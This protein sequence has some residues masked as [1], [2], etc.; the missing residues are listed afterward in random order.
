MSTSK[1]TKTEGKGTAKNSNV[2]PQSMSAQKGSTTILTQDPNVTGNRIL[3]PADGPY[4]LT[5][6][7]RVIICGPLSLPGQSL[8]VECGEIGTQSDTKGNAAVISVTGQNGAP[9]PAPTKPAA[10]GSDGKQAFTGNEPSSFPG[11]RGSGGAAGR[12]GTAGGSGGTISVIALSVA[13]GTNLTLNAEGG[14]GGQGQRGERGGNGGKGGTCFVVL[15]MPDAEHLMGTGRVIPPG[16]GGQGGD[17]GS[18][19][20]GGDG[21]KGGNPGQGG[22]GGIGFT[23]APLIPQKVPD[24]DT[25]RD[26]NPGKQGVRGTSGTDGQLTIN[27]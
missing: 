3:V 5:T 2:V 15:G 21:G 26:G 7:G 20:V 16:P 27:Q 18:G 19:G 24:G 14:K 9:P 8:S 17:G 25:G 23:G 6:P 13:S 12:P 22:T 11:E 10:N 4:S 1:K